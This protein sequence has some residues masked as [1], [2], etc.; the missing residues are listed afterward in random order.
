MSREVDRRHYT[1]APIPEGRREELRREVAQISDGLPGT[2]SLTVTKFDDTIGV[3]RVI[4]SRGAPVETGDYVARALDHVQRLAPAFGLT[5]GGQQ[6]Q[7]FQ[8][9][10]QVQR[11]PTGAA[12]VHLQQELAGIPI[13]QATETVRFNPDGSLRDT[14]GSSV[15]VAVPPEA[16]PAIAAEEAV[17]RAAAYVAEPS[18]QEESGHDHDAFGEPLPPLRVDVTGFAPERV[19]GGEDALR[20]AARFRGAPFEDDITAALIWF[21]ISDAVRL[22]WEVV[23]TFPGYVE[24]WRTIVDAADG[25][26]LYCARLVRSAVKANVYRVDG[27]RPREVVTLPLDPGDYDISGGPAVPPSFPGDWVGAQGDTSGNCAHAHLGV[28]GATYV[29]TPQGEDLVFDPEDP[30]GDDQKVLNIFY[31]NCVMHDLCYLMGFQEVN[32]NFQADNLGRG[33]LGGD[34]V[35]ARAHSGAVPGT[36]NM[37]TREDGRPPVMNMGLVASTGRHTAFDSSVVFHEFMHGVTN[38]LVGG[39][40]DDASLEAPQSR[41]MGEGWS[42]WIACTINGTEVVGDWV[43]A[44]PAGIRRAPYD[45]A[46]PFTFG[47]LMGP[48]YDDEHLVGEVW[49]AILMSLN[50]ALGVPLAR[51]LVF[52]AL[53]LAAAS[54]SFLDMRDDLLAAAR[55]RADAG[56]LPPLTDRSL[57][58]VL[59][60]MWKVFA[61]YGIG[62]QARSQGAQMLGIVP[63]FGVPGVPATTPA[64]GG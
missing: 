27:S 31:Y 57:D 2:H 56:Q 52:D 39:P 22:G 3:P 16:E 30:F 20:R 61:H 18:G 5:A 11:T 37:A 33:G 58:D 50:R 55:M 51:A 10:E 47:D 4:A 34:A 15:P 53:H 13:F 41:G 43:V 14:A 6:A 49:C 63:D 44:D 40:D 35:D 25:E 62:P 8:A 24:R 29:G 48:E 7:E 28:A 1:D 42:D 23:L 9:A 38:R 46:F 17:R 59:A 21:P 54:P 45:E 19:D 60:A 32:G 36:A 64:V 26:I 12:V